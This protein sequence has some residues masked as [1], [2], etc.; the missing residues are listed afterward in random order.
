MDHM[1]GSITC[2]NVMRLKKATRDAL[3]AVFL[4]SFQINLVY[5]M[6]EEENR[7]YGAVNA[8]EIVVPA[9]PMGGASVDAAGDG[10]IASGAAD[11]V[12]EAGVTDFEQ[13]AEVSPIADAEETDAVETG[14]VLTGAVETGSAISSASP[15][16]VANPATDRTPSVRSGAGAGSPVSFMVGGAS[17]R[18]LS[19][20]LSSR[21]K[22]NLR[23]TFSALTA[24]LSTCGDKVR[25]VL[26][27]QDAEHPVPSRGSLSRLASGALHVQGLPVSATP[28]LKTLISAV[29]QLTANGS[30]DDDLRQA[31]ANVYR[32]RC[33]LP[34]TT[35]ASVVHAV[36]E[37]AA[38]SAAAPPMSA[39]PQAGPSPL[40]QSRPARIS[41]AGPARTATTAKV[42]ALAIGAAPILSQGHPGKSSYAVVLVLPFRVIPSW[43]EALATLLGFVTRRTSLV[44][45]VSRAL[46]ALCSPD[47][48]DAET[49]LKRALDLAEIFMLAGAGVERDK[50]YDP[51]EVLSKAISLVVTE[52]RSSLSGGRADLVTL[53]VLQTLESA[54]TFPL[55]VA[56]QRQCAARTTEINS[57]ADV[58][59]RLWVRLPS[60]AASAAI[61]ASAATAATA[62]ASATTAAATVAAAAAGAAATG[63]A[64]IQSAGSRVFIDD[65]PFS[66]ALNE[67]VDHAVVKLGNGHE[68]SDC[69]CEGPHNVRFISSAVQL[70]LTLVIPF[71]SSF[72]SSA[73][74]SYP[75]RP[76]PS[77]TTLLGGIYVL[78]VIWIHCTDDGHR[79]EYYISVVLSEGRWFL[80]DA[81]VTTDIG[82]AEMDVI[83]YAVNFLGPSRGEIHS[84]TYELERTAGAVEPEADA[85]EGVSMARAASES[86]EASPSASEPGDVVSH[87]LVPGDEDVIKAALAIKRDPILASFRRNDFKRSDLTLLLTNGWLNDSIIN[88]FGGLLRVIG[89][90]SL[91]G[92]GPKALGWIFS[93]FFYTR[94]IQDTTRYDY[95]GVERWTKTVDVFA[96]ERL[97][98]PINRGNTHWALAVID[99]RNLTVTYYDSLRGMGADVCA[100]LIR[101]INDEHLAKK[102]SPLPN[103]YKEAPAPNDLARQR[104]GYDCGVFVC[105]SMLSL[106]FD[107]IPT[108]ASVRQCDIPLFRQKIAADILSYCRDSISADQGLRGGQPGA[109][110]LRGLNRQPAAVTA[111]PDADAD[112]Q[113][114]A[115][116]ATGDGSSAA[117]AGRASVTAADVPAPDAA[118]DADADADAGG[119]ASGAAQ[120]SDGRKR[121]RDNSQIEAG[122]DDEVDSDVGEGES[123]NDEG[124]EDDVKR[125]KQRPGEAA[126]SDDESG[127]SRLRKRVGDFDG[128]EPAA[129]CK[130]CNRLVRLN[131]DN[132]LKKHRMMKG[133][134]VGGDCVWD[135]RRL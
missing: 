84:C 73:D 54:F 8:K 38:Q 19:T 56:R 97:I 34:E 126:A 66:K 28:V 9:A 88:F 52:V 95:P 14:A 102:K 110:V 124:S 109:G 48:L 118:P 79:G 27:V 63:S 131:H 12:V 39:A 69:L 71:E 108:A 11:F 86:G 3:T 83:T 53:S 15:I 105:I 100:T 78:K 133:G 61:A 123:V 114:A 117:L 91:R 5:L 111:A 41:P 40:V 23:D 62:A 7:A 132:T 42:R 29:G 121:P 55:L 107:K 21:R 135:Q 49:F 57:L 44:A 51:F 33:I 70:P 85:N 87:R 36:S 20:N 128:P 96:Y 127:F 93:S 37:P 130:G 25:A 10:A 103:V 134:R 80:C 22:Q 94:L 13:A 104:N 77:L 30:W 64:S 50:E 59:F 116:A 106:L 18:T 81:E 112:R 74:L 32:T 4:G 24:K 90:N 129:R 113:P 31:M 58:F 65:T 16:A 120:S 6:G 89:E 67:S 75:V 35:A 45:P 2:I 76:T 72:R 122:D 125:S 98:F 17:H 60:S 119:G 115:A 1:H 68:S 99:T 46:T 47:P 92:R 101:W 26:Y 43:R 82:D